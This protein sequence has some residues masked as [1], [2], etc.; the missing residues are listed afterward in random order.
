MN[1][2]LSSNTAYRDQ[3]SGRAQSFLPEEKKRE[4]EKQKKEDDILF[5][6]YPHVARNLKSVYSRK[7]CRLFFRDDFPRPSRDG[8]RR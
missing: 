1:V 7:I 3:F 5:P 2:A 6:C 4:R 8:H